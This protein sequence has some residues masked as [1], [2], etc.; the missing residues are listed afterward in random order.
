MKKLINIIGVIVL[1][2]I[3]IKL[4]SVFVFLFQKLDNGFI[5]AEITGATF[6]AA[7]IY[8]VVKIESKWLKI[9]MVALDVLTILY[10]YLHQQLKFPIEYA[11]VIV[12][13]YSGL[14]VFFL[15]KIVSEQINSANASETEQLRNELN[16]LRIDNDISHLETE[17]KRAQRR[18]SE[19]TGETKQRNEQKL[20]ELESKLYKLKN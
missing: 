12:A 13:A 3:L 5:L 20:K 8:F 7:S 11:S 2:G 18:V 17:I 6:A 10:Y 14:I 1:L 16:R 9:T 4:S 19:S 15:G